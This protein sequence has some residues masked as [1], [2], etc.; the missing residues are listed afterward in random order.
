MAKQLNVDLRFTANNAQA[1]QQIQDLQIALDKLMTTSSK[2][3]SGLG[4]TK[5][6][7]QA[8]SEVAKLQAMLESS[9]NTSGG[10]DLG[11]FNQA[12]AQGQIK[13]SDYAKTLSS[14]G[15]QGDQAF[16]KL[17][18]AITSAE[19]PLKR[20]N[21]LLKE[22]KTSLANTARWQLS[23]S[24]LHGFM[25]AVQSAYGYAQDLNESL[26]NIRI[27]TGQ[28]IEQMTA[29]AKKANKAAQALSTTTT[30]YTDA[31]LIYYQQGLSD[32]EVAKR[33]E[34]T[35]KMANAAGQSA[36]VV[37]D[38]L[39]AVWNN[40]YDGS[41]SLEYYADVMTALGAA[42]ASSTD[43]I[44]GGLEKFAA[45][46]QTIGL[47]YEYAASALAT[48]T[49]N[50]RESE[51][52]VGTALKTIFA[53]IQGLQ[54]GETL[55]D[56]VTLNK[57]S[58]ALRKVG[59]SIFDSNGE[60]KKMD[61]ILDELGSKWDTLN[62]AQQ[63]ALA[64]TV[65]GARQYN[66]L[67]ALMNNWDSGDADSMQANLATAYGSEGTLQEQADIYAESWEA[68]RDR[69]TAAA[70]EIYNQLLNDKFFIALNNGFAGFLNIVS[71]TIDTLGGLPG[72]L[73][74]ASSIMFRMFG[75]DMAKAIDDWGYNIKLR[76]SEGVQEILKLRQESVEA[77][78]NVYADNVDTGPVN[79]TSQA[80][81]ESQATIADT[82]LVKKQQLLANGQA[83]SDQ[84]ERQ[85]QLLL[86][87]NEAYGEQA[88]ESA[89]ALENIQ[90]QS[91]LL[92]SQVRIQIRRYNKGKQ[93]DEKIDLKAEINEIKQAQI[94]Y[95]ALES[96]LNKLSRA[97]GNFKSGDDM[98]AALKA[99][100]DEAANAGMDVNGFYQILSK[101]SSGMS[102]DEVLNTIETEMHEI[103]DAAYEAI[104][105]GEGLRVKL[106]QIGMSDQQI[107]KL[108]ESWE[109]QGVITSE[110]AE[111]LRNVKV[112]GDEANAAINKTGV[113]QQYH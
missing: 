41:K 61:N 110:V 15:P 93:D 106:Q 103:G 36:K 2:S 31:S 76:S 33:T 13:I 32:S 4:I 105:G 22:F 8:T 37:S 82:L 104:E 112:Q 83:L 14:L 52:V 89:H 6:I 100:A 48:I 88:I 84:D 96:T 54:L 49:S 34:V 107:N 56:G 65:A 19:V 64:Q 46:G 72:V 53:R 108:I 102:V 50:T 38:Q 66:Q 95:S 67:I 26:N 60:L 21:G 23:S 86:K 71:N 43:E 20:T 90:K 18:K 35:I 98:I 62:K 55:D 69:V 81:F 27:V 7:A 101:L 12:L 44:A 47:S 78:K 51:E 42:T 57:Y 113:P 11:K 24:V 70:E 59:I 75:K 79:A 99:M 58:E 16:A 10:L 17:A 40:F 28:N 92:E 77:L 25:G 45:I 39:T 91:D 87:I 74:L 85:A 1:K 3:S 29:F 9:K 97:K 73:T 5:D 30:E 80:S 94:Q 68:A 111:K 109:K 63:V